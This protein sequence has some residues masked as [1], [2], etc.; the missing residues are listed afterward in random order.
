MNAV[1]EYF[2]ARF[3]R[4]KIPEVPWRVHAHHHLDVIHLSQEPLFN[5]AFCGET[6]WGETQLE[7]YRGSQVPGFAQIKDRSRVA[8]VF[9]HRF[10]YQHRSALW[11]FFKG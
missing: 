3:S 6:E 5:E 10:L 1:I 11:Q 7:V 2:H 4:E 8:E 9:P